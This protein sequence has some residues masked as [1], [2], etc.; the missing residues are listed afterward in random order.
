MAEP[1]QD[2][3]YQL[4]TERRQMGFLYVICGL[5][6]FGLTVYLLIILFVNHSF[7]DLRYVT[8]LLAFYIWLLT[9]V[10][11]RKISQSAQI[12][13][14]VGGVGYFLQLY[15]DVHDISTLFFFNIYPI[16][17][18]FL[19][20]KRGGVGYTGIFA[21]GLV[22]AYAL[23]LAGIVPLYF[24]PSDMRDFAIAF[25]IASVMVYYY[26]DLIAASQEIIRE[27]DML[28][29]KERDQ[30]RAVITSIGE[31]VFVIDKN[32]LTRSINPV[33][34]SLLG[35]P[36]AEAIGQPIRALFTLSKN[37]IPLQE[38]EYPGIRALHTAQT[39][40][41]SIDD[42][43]YCH[44]ANTT[45]PISIVASPIR[46]ATEAIDGA[47][48]VFRDITADKKAKELIEQE[49]QERTKELEQTRV[50]LLASINSLD[51]GYIMTNHSPE[52]VLANNAAYAILRHT[53]A[54][55]KTDIGIS[56]PGENL[57]LSQMQ[58]KFG[59]AYDLS[60]KIQSV[61]ETKTL[62]RM[63]DV[64]Y[65]DRILEVVISPIILR[66]DVIG[67]V[68]LM[69]DVTE[70]KVIERSKDEF[71]SIASHELRTPLTAI[72][73]YS[74]LLQRKVASD[75][76]D[77]DIRSMVEGIHNESARLIAIVN[78]F[79]DSSRLEQKRMV[80]SKEELDILDII[81]DVKHDFDLAAG[82]KD[83]ALTVI[84]PPHLPAVI[85]DRQRTKQI[86]VNLVGNAFKFT[87]SGA[88]TIQPY[89]SDGYVGVAVHDTGP[90]IPISNQPLLF[91]KF[92]QA[93][94][95]IITRDVSHGT[96]LGLYISKLLAQGMGGTVWLVKSEVNK[97]S[98]FAFVLPQAGGKALGKKHETV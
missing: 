26:Q 36:S 17:V 29:A 71:F 14:L 81:N 95:S 49:V 59:S 96:G 13:A 85:A 61:M 72:R 45:F 8:P 51:H 27:R 9:Q 21:S 98:T 66:S 93:G 94:S 92:Q 16:F 58:Q 44:T 80:Y 12:V 33:T 75:N 62:A 54:E 48:I 2:I 3:S 11:K 76:A 64:P 78:D 50:R 37:D 46:T 82:E 65:G 47:V 74:A 15:T 25:L 69:Q 83:I 24:E 57:T 90:G 67:T 68:I 1:N 34:Q 22:I 60:Q 88:I 40:A 87:Q 18:F 79:L 23:H 20:G 19:L 39:I 70:L 10:R 89:V 53:R 28:L 38:E 4:A 73:G 43:I 91:H 41:V 42:D 31:G 84:A 7:N 97:G 86:L 56:S 52:V 77:K 63:K 55:E 5:S 6:I 32:G 30:A 35:I